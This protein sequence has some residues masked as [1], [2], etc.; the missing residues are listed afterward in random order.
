V[1]L[2]DLIVTPI[3]LIIIYVLAYVVRPYVTDSVN[4]RY[5]IPALTLRII[6]ALAVGFV[7]Q[8]YYRGGD[9]FNYHTYGSRYIWEAWLDSPSKGFHIFFYGPENVQGVYDYTEKILFLNDPGS[10]VIVR[11]AFLCDLFTFSSYS[12]TAVLFSLFSFVGMWM[13][14]LTFYEMYQH[15]HFRLAVASFFIPSVF[16]WGSGILKDTI[17]LACLGVAVY[18]CYQI[19]IKTRISFWNLLLLP[20]SLYIIYKVKVYILLTFLPSAIIWIFLS[21][22]GKIRI[23]IIKLALFPIVTISSLSLAYFAIVK[24][25]ETSERYS[26]QNLARTAQI[27]AYDIRYFTGRDAGSG[28]SLGELDGSFGSMLQLAPAAINVTLFRPFL[29]EVKNPLMLLVSLEGL[30]FLVAF[31]IVILQARF[32]IFTA[33]SN[34]NVLFVFIFSVTF[35]FAVGVSTFNFGTLARYKIPLLPFFAVMLTLIHSYIRRHRAEREYLN[36]Q[37]IADRQ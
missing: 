27:T 33:L 3:L 6:G 14:F 17:T 1:E 19:F 20:V 24:A 30:I 34:P 15:L 5:F 8:F 10:F 7:Y 4:R 26:I 29:W 35:A 11:L 31:V 25:G 28:Y 13:F 18:T 2:R 32:L 9:T 12:G 16:F 21:Q 37:N 22:L 36:E 23:T